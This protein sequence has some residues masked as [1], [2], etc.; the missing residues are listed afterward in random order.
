MKPVSASSRRLRLACLL[1]GGLFAGLAVW[2]WLHSQGYTVRESVDWALARVRSV[3]PVT[4][5]TLMA[6]VPAAGAPVTI[7]T[8]TAG[9]VFAPTL[10]MPQVLLL[11]YASLG[12]NLVFTYWLARWLLRPWMVRLCA[13]LGYGIPA[14]ARENQR[15]LVVLLRITPG[16]PYAL[17]NYLLGVAGIPFPTYFFTSWLLVSLDASLYILFGDAVVQGKGRWVAVAAG[18]FIG[19]ALAVK[20]LRSR[21]RA[22]KAEV[23]SA[24][25][26]SAAKRSEA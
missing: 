21:L 6:L 8:F 2:A 26:E 14:V 22:K 11:T 25:T 9:S 7:F 4:F 13:W 19:L 20:L 24:L 23:V 1:A 5:F 3:G 15:S 12:I 10:G 18:L 16:P 17:Q